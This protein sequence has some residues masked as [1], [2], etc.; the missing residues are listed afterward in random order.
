MTPAFSPLFSM[1]RRRHRLL[2]WTGCALLLAL[3]LNLR[4]EESLKSVFTE[5]EYR[6]AGLD[7]LSPDEQAALMQA[8]QKRGLWQAAPATPAPAP[9]PVAA[10][11]A[12]PVAA[13]AAAPAET[14]APR[15][16]LW[17]RIKDF[18]AE[19]LPIKSDKDEGEVT[20]VE[21]QMVEPFTGL[22]GKT[23]FHLDNGQIWQQRISETFYVGQPIPNPMVT[24]KRTRFGY[25]LFIPAVSPGFDVSVKRIK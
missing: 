12:A 10:A 1:P 25:R 18:G 11:P 3:A 5:A 15:K 2:G 17:A 8:L 21:A 6:Q 13:A 19:Q 14:P 22:R 9:T 24:L 7:K 20:E 23:L 4:A 16:G